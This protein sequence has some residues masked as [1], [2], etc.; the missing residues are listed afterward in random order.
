ML[1]SS[2]VAE[3]LCGRT[4][5]SLAIRPTVLDR[6]LLTAA[7]RATSICEQGCPATQHDFLKKYRQR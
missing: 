2:L 3:G 7:E 5:P 6:R 1:V 4:V